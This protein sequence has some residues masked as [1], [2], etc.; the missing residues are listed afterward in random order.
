ML[1]T[2]GSEC[3]VSS[4]VIIGDANFSFGCDHDL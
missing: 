2:I 1:F 4:K 3:I